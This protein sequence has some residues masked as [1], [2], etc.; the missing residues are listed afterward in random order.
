MAKSL[1]TDRLILKPTSEE[2]AEFM[3]VLMNSPKWLKFIG[4][5]GVSTLKVAEKYI[6]DNY[7]KQRERLG[8][9]TF[10]ILR[11]EDSQKLGVVGLYDRE[12]LEGIDFG[13]ALQ[14]VFEGQGYAFEASKK[15][16]EE[17]TKNY[18]IS[19]LKAITNK[20]NS[21]SQRLLEKLGFEKNANVRLT[22]ESEEVLLYVI[23]LGG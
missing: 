6:A 9:S 4:D 19:H 15:L 5:R 10:T 23:E 20:D 18:K 7:V 1:E 16:L 11:K 3:L 22:K 14:S 8:F 13:F 12:G 2:D 21:S 17:A